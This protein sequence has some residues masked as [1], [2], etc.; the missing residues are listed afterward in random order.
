[1]LSTYTVDIF[2]TYVNRVQ[3]SAFPW[4]RVCVQRPISLLQALA[5]NYLI[6]DSL[7]SHHQI[8]T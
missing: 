1:M 7:P 2:M 4:W 3:V 5:N 6:P 8:G